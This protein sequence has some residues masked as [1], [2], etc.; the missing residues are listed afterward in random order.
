MLWRRA[1]A[2]LV[3]TMPLSA[4]VT[5]PDAATVV[6]SAGGTGADDAYVVSSVAQEYE[7]LR[8]LGLTM[9]RKALH[10]IDGRAFD[11]LSVRDPAT[12]AMRDVWFDI[13]RFF[14]RGY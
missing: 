5:P 13:S 2:V 12:G 7:I 6:A 1:L 10:V 3:A 8:L 4:C 9:E 11:V 14:R